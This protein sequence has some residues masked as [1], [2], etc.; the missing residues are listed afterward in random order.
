MSEKSKRRQVGR[1]PGNSTDKAN[2][3]EDIL[4]E[5]LEILGEQGFTH[6]SLKNVSTRVG[7]TPAALY[8]YFANKN[9]LIEETLGHFVLP[10]VYGLW[11]L[12]DLEDDPVK[13]V[14]A[15]MDRLIEIANSSPWFLPMWA[16][17]LADPAQPLRRY[18]TQNVDPQTIH[19]F[20][21]KLRKAKENNI[22][23]P[24]LLPDML[25]ISLFASIFIPLLS[26]S[27][28]T[29]SWGFDITPERLVAHIRSMTLK[30][31]F[32]PHVEIAFKDSPPLTL[33]EPP[34]K[35]L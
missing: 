25:Y 32:M 11:E 2:L 28:W 3:R 26:I 22:V 7:V 9:A 6:F 4:K 1:P 31:V 30:G 34:P 17:E 13:M 12:M 14:V 19:R 5:A 29:D 35:P 15:L 16:R 10:V 8:H 24:D 27:S 18:L 21:E 23:N 20:C 33:P